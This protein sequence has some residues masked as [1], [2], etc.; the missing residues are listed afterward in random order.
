LVGRQM[1]LYFRPLLVAKPKQAR[2]H[3]LA[4]IR[5]TKPLNQHMVN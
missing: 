5:L 3:R 2:I 1:L 4:P